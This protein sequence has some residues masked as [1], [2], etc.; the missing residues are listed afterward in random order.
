MKEFEKKS[1]EYHLPIKV[2]PKD[3][4]FT[5]S[6]F[7]R[8]GKELFFDLNYG[9]SDRN[10]GMILRT[11][12]SDPHTYKLINHVLWMNDKPQYA[13][14]PTPYDESL[15]NPTDI[16]LWH[17]RLS[18]EQINVFSILVQKMVRQYGIDNLTEENIFSDEDIRGVL[19]LDQTNPFAHIPSRTIPENKVSIFA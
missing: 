4:C 14:K 6:G 1:S 7:I 13:N 15:Y 8:E 18:L 12:I 10:Q 5:F 2:D 16:K 17:K 19:G 11:A 3:Q 9:G